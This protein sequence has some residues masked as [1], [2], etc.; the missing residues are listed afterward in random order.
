MKGYNFKANP[1][2][3]E[4][5]IYK[6]SRFEGEDKYLGKIILEDGKIREE[7]PNPANWLPVNQALA[8]MGLIT[9]ERANLADLGF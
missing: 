6:V 1:S 5:E 8:E 2:N 4:C 7:K 3:T 9:R